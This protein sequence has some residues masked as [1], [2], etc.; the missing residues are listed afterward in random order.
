MMAS[1]HVL[2][3]SALRPLPRQLDLN[4]L[5]LCWKQPVS[6]AELTMGA[7]PNQLKPAIVGVPVNQNEIRF[8]M[9]IS[10]IFPLSAKRVIDVSNGQRPIF[11]EK[12]NHRLE[13]FV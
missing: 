8:E 11:R 9:A 7:K 13:I 1:R 5:C 6:Q 2:S 4:S 12:I 10:V 3:G